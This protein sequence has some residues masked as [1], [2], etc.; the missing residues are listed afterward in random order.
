[1][2]YAYGIL[3]FYIQNRPAANLCKGKGEG[4]LFFE[5]RLGQFIVIAN[6]TYYIQFY[7]K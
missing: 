2:P 7:I 4:V 5:I 1:M 3:F 6:P